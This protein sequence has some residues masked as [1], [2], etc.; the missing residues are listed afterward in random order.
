MGVMERSNEIMNRR[1]FAVTLGTIVAGSTT[2]SRLFGQEQPKK[3]DHPGQC[4]GTETLG[5]RRVT[6]SG[7]EK[8]S[9]EKNATT[10]AKKARKAKAKDST[11]KKA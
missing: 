10:K 9:N 4:A 1:T 6:D 3:T 8:N 5:D 11:E 7:V 2:I